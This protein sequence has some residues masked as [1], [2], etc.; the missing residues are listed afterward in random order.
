M[1]FRPTSIA[2][3]T[4]KGDCLYEKKRKANARLSRSKPNYEM[5]WLESSEATLSKSRHNSLWLSV[6]CACSKVHRRHWA[7]TASRIQ[8]PRTRS[9]RSIDLWTHGG[10]DRGKRVVRRITAI[11][12][13]AA[14]YSR[15]E[16]QRR[17]R[18]RSTFKEEPQIT[19]D[20]S[21]EDTKDHFPIV[22]K[23]A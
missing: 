5:I 10:S 23:L 11:E 17:G 13:R 6:L 20:D 8:H 21:E 14:L 19:S 16:T 7:C 18:S 22:C 4:E 15:E 3:G 2:E 9:C 12:A 1:D